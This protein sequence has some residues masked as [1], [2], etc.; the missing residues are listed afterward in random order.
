MITNLSYP[1]GASINDD[2]NSQFCTLTD[3]MVDAV[4]REAAKLGRGSLLAKADIES[5]YC[6][7][8]VHPE[9][10]PL[11]AIHWGNGILV[12]AKLPFRLCSAPKIFTALMDGLEWVV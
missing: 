2:I 3:V 12:D 8:P 10:R 11:L 1:S 5:A 7:I 4:T 9:D 6:L